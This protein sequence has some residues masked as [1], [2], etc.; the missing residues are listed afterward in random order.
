MNLKVDLVHW[1]LIRML[2]STKF[3]SMYFWRI[4]KLKQE[5]A[6]RPL[7]ERQA[8]PYLVVY[9]ALYSAA[10]FVSPELENHWDFAGAIWSLLIVILGTIHIYHQNG[11]NEGHHF[12]QRYFAIGWVVGL[13]WLAIWVVYLVAF[14]VLLGYFGPE[15]EGSQWYDFLGIALFE[16]LIYWRIGCHVRDLAMRTKTVIRPC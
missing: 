14:Y 7:T 16:T 11:G 8:L 5:M 9:C 6:A 10:G 2:G 13:R 3:C 4:E 1:L 12:L 15:V